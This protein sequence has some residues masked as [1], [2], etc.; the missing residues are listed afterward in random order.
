MSKSRGCGIA[1]EA[2]GENGRTGLHTDIDKC[3]QLRVLTRWVEC[4]SADAQGRTGRVESTAVHQNA[5]DFELG[6]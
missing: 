3:P 1:A 5:E 6:L 2:E 4:V